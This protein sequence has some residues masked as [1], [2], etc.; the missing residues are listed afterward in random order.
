MKI[1]P[2]VLCSTLLSTSAFASN[3]NIIIDTP[4]SGAQDP[5]INGAIASD[6]VVVGKDSSFQGTGNLIIGSNSTSHNESVAIGNHT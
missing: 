5:V 2:F 4:K 6:N 3:T 1:L